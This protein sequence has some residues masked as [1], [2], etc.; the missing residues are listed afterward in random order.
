MVPHPFPFLGL[1]THGTL[2]VPT[3]ATPNPNPNPTHRLNHHPTDINPAH[4]L[5]HSPPVTA[6]EEEEMGK[7]RNEG[8]SH[9][10]HWHQ[11]LPA[12]V[13]YRQVSL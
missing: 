12:I 10:S 7:G 2:K 1:V 3:P 6:E 11:G 9:L 13:R 4:R 5:L 8:S